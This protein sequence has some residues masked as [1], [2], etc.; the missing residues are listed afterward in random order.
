MVIDGSL[1]GTRGRLEAM[2]RRGGCWIRP[3]RAICDGTL[4]CE[5]SGRVN[6]RVNQLAAPTGLSDG[7]TIPTQALRWKTGEISGLLTNLLYQVIIEADKALQAVTKGRLLKD[8]LVLSRVRKSEGSP[9]NLSVDARLSVLTM[10]SFA[11]GGEPEDD[12]WRAE[13]VESG[14]MLTSPSVALQGLPLLVEALQVSCS[15]AAL[16]VV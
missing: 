13:G 9:E 8:Y 15:G 16:L 2:G 6:D 3:G 12:G 5:A 4:E 7:G 14:L 1:T 10:E 11:C